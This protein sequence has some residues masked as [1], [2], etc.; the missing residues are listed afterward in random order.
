MHFIQRSTAVLVLALALGRSAQAQ[1]PPAEDDDVFTDLVT[2][3]ER[4]DGE[5]KTPA[6]TA[7]PAQSFNPDIAVVAGFAVA[8]F[9][10]EDHLQTGAHDP[11]ETGFNLQ[12]LELSIQAAV[13]PYFRFDSF[14][15]FSLFGVEIEEVYGTTTALPGDLQLRFGQFLTRFGR[16]N[17]THPHAWDFVDQ[18][19]AIGRIFGAEG[20]RALGLEVSWLAPLPWYAEIVASTTRADGD[21][22]NRS[23]FGGDN[24]GVEGPE[25]LLYVTALKQ[26]F[27]LSH[28]W[29]LLWG[30]SAA[31]GPNSTGRSNRTEVYGT[32]LFVKYRPIT[33]ES[34]LQLKWQSE[35][36]HRRVQTPDT[37]LYDHS[38]YTQLVWG[39]EKQWAVGARYEW[40]SPTYNLDGT[41][42]VQPLDPEWTDHRHRVSSALTFLPTEFSRLRLQASMDLPAWRDD[43]IF[44][45]FLA[46]ELAVGAHGA[47]PF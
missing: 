19:F 3:L 29:S 37:V 33:R 5:P 31:F 39:F 28:D 43:P 13:D 18:P 25:D 47:H 16:I 26:F 40:G 23:F 20:N 14:I 12:E 11:T 32:D 42:V 2:E 9:D 44:A 24:L 21:A 8:V 22:S 6:G 36:F 15:V 4:G 41:R 1:A 45:A 30:L 27:D 35:L 34:S 7:Q 10:E 46:A 17:P 38:L